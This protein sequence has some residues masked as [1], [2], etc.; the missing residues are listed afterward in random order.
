LKREELTEPGTGAQQPSPEPVPASSMTL[1]FLVAASLFMENLDSTILVTAIPDMAA[2]FGV[3]P[4]DLG[5][6]VS[7]YVLTLAI[8]IPLSGW[9]A[10]RFGSRRVF[11]SAIIIFTGASILCGLSE[12]LLTFTLARVLQGIGGAMMVPVGRLVVLRSIDKKDMIRAITTLTWPGL[13]APVLGPP[14]GGFITMYLS[15]HWIFFINVP[16]GI[17]AF[18]FTLRLMPKEKIHAARPFDVLGFVLTGAACF[19]LMYGVELFTHEDVSWPLVAAAIAVGFASGIYAIVHARRHRHPLVELWA[20]SVPS[21]AAAVRGGSAVR[22]AIHAIPFL[23]PLLFQVSLGLDPLTSGLLILSVFAGN[24][25]M[26]L[27]TTRLLHRFGFRSV[28]II[29][30][31]LNALTIFACMLITAETPFAVIVVLLFLSGLTRSLQFTAV[32]ALTYADVPQDRM[33]GANTLSN[34]AQQMAMGGGVALGA[35]ALRFAEF[36]NP[37]SAGPGIPAADFQIAF[38]I[39]G[40]VALLAALDA[41]RLAPNVGEAIRR[42]RA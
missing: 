38:F 14:L 41:I 34:M 33:N 8:L 6:G 9:M 39:V 5:I 31:I 10:D 29:N 28:L 27:V 24:L 36:V 35:L 13:A 19:S 22:V 11:A 42:R 12:S 15:W 25:V 3:R 16:L 23:L 26:K 2:A 4:V 32:N 30:G 20:M 7:A 21:Y 1:T 37:A 17:A 40:M 18:F